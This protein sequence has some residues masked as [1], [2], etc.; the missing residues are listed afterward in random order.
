MDKWLK[1]KKQ[2]RIQIRELKNGQ[3]VQNATEANQGTGGNDEAIEIL[4]AELKKA[5]QDNS[6]LQIVNI[7]MAEEKTTL[8]SQINRLQVEFENIKGKYDHV[9]IELT[10]IKEKL[11][12]QTA[13]EEHLQ[14]EYEECLQNLKEEENRNVELLRTADTP[15][16]AVTTYHEPTTEESFKSREKP[17]RSDFDR[18]SRTTING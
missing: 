12:I 1:E 16:E 14:I 7:E 10:D 13:R 9:N 2:F 3:E 6:D 18:V 15:P 4:E 8:Q 11:R 17:P 5:R